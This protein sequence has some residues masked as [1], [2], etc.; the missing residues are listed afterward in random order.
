M[1]YQMLLPLLCASSKIAKELKSMILG[2]HTLRLKVYWDY[3]EPRFRDDQWNMI[4]YPHTVWPP[5]K[6]DEIDTLHSI[7]MEV[8]PL[9][10][11]RVFRGIKITLEV[12]MATK[13][14][15]GKR[16]KRKLHDSERAWSVREVDW[17][18]PVRELKN[19]GFEKVEELEIEV[20]Y[21]PQADS[22]VM[23]MEA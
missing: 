20:K 19:F 13:E 17:L 7:K 6:R 10:L 23:N 18:Y 21:L 16:M 1:R 8:P 12:P 11:T 2:N 15:L 4:M 22:E 3:G 5:A 9:K 14:K